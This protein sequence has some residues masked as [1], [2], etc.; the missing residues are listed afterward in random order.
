M[1]IL[2]NFNPWGPPL[3]LWAL[4]RYVYRNRLYNGLG[5]INADMVES[6]QLAQRT[7]IYVL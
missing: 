1:N 3:T 4:V 7:K 5:S 2:Y 6:K